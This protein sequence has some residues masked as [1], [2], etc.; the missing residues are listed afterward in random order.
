MVFGIDHRIPNGTPL[1]NYIY[2]VNTARELLNLPPLSKD[3]K[4]WARQAF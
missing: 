2:Y 3:K 4:G 1:E